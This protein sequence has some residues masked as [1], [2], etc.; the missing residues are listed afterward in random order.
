MRDK[1]VTYW[2]QAVLDASFLGRSVLIGRNLMQSIRLHWPRV[3]LDA[4]LSDC[5]VLNGMDLVKKIEAE[6]SSSGKPKTQVTIAKSGELPKKS[7]V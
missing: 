5:A 7:W 4:F 2:P 1:K 3:V 6:G